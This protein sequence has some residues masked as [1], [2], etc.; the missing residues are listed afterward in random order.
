[1]SVTRRLAAVSTLVAF[2]LAPLQAS[3]PMRVASLRASS[4]TAA[5][6]SAYVPGELIVQFREGAT[7]ADMARVTRE[8]GGLRLRK[9]AFH[10]RAR[11]TLDDGFTVA[12]SMDRLRGRPE[13][14]IVEPN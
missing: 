10:S 9:S 13:V 5:A 14:E 12:E 1:M 8:A 2:G 3:E 6:A 11:V 4:S 7:D